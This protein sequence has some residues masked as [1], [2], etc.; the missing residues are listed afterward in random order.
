[1]VFLPQGFHFTPILFLIN[2]NDTYFISY[3]N[4]LPFPDDL[5]I[6]RTANSLDDA[7]C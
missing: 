1:M 4:M 5:K 2:I 3:L 6:C 7:D